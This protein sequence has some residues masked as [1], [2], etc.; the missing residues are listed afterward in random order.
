MDGS[1]PIERA[2]LALAGK[3]RSEKITGLS[4]AVMARAGLKFE[5]R[6][7]SAIPNGAIL[8]EVRSLKTDKTGEPTDLAI[9]LDL[10]DDFVYSPQLTPYRLSRIGG[11]F[12]HAFTEEGISGYFLYIY[13]PLTGEFLEPDQ[14]L[15]PEEPPKYVPETDQATVDMAKAAGKTINPDVRVVPVINPGQP[16]GSLSGR[17]VF[18]NQSH[19]WFDDVDFGRWRVQRGNTCSGMEDL[20]S[21]EF[22]NEYVMPMLR[23]TG[24]KVM[25]VREP[26]TQTAMLIVDNSDTGAGRADGR[27]FETGTWSNS[28]IEGFKQK[29]T[30]SWTGTSI[31]PFSQGTGQNRLSPALTA[32][33]PTG[34]ANWVANIPADGYYNVYASWSPFSG[35]ANDAQYLVYHSGG[36]S[37]VRMN[38]KIDGYTWVLLGNWYFEASAPESERK[39]VLTNKSSDGTGVNVSA[40]A[41]RWGGGLGDMARQTHGVSGRPRWEEEAVNYLQFTGF[42]RSGDLY[43]GTDDE[44]GGWADRPQYARWEHSGKDGGV[45]DAVY[46]AWHTNAFNGTSGNCDGT[47]QGLSSFRHSTATTDSTTLQ[48]IMHD[49]L[50]NH[51]DTLWFTASTWQV[52]SKNVTNFGENNQSSLGSNLPGFLL[53]GLFHDNTDDTNAYQDPRF[54]KLAARAFAHGLIDYFNQRDST[55][56]PYPPEPPLNFRVEALGGTSVRLSWTAGASG[57]FNGAA[58]TSYKVFRSRNGFGF[59]DGTVVN[60]LTVTLTDAPTDRVEYYRICAVNTGGQS[61]P[62]ETLCAMNGAGSQVLIVNGFDRNQTSLAP[63]Q[64]ITNL[65]TVRRFDERLFQGYNYII[66]HAEA[67]EPLGLRISSSCNERVADGTTALGGF[68]AVFWICGQESTSDDA[69]NSSEISRVTTYLSGGG[70]FFVSGSEIGWDLGRSGVS[71]AAD[72]TFYNTVLRTAYSSDSAGTYNLSSTGIFSGLGS[73]NFSPASGARY[74]TPTPDVI[75]P[76]NGSTTILSYSGGVGGTAAVA[77]NGTSRVISLGFPFETISSKLTR[78]AMMQST[79][80]FF[81]L[82]SGPPASVQDWKKF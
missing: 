64:T 80:T 55:T 62:T 4:T 20:S 81:G 24:A 7:I 69:F 36:V 6:S 26:D 40:D 54:R 28:S 66:E 61:F 42:G 37:E 2:R 43:T 18:I 58:A 17:T 16:Q 21:A 77:Y 68:A 41:I 56:R 51:I 50:Y 63:T 30:A 15:P 1:C 59:D 8:T 35:R 25:T 82:T 29:T 71:S 34:T 52:R 60:G 76:S 19:G 13:D 5:G 27:Y 11:E 73:F 23:N 44:S 48:T 14:L 79:A 53:E 47:A 49:K 78:E 3:S 31:N 38:Q 57:G 9:Y 33:T 12:V 10:G 75:S 74:A 65:G 70:R 46:V 67:L 72:V 22:I 39:V 32:G 45:E